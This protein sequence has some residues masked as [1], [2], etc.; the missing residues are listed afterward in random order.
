MWIYVNMAGSD[1]SKEDSNSQP[2]CE[3]EQACP[4]VH[5]NSYQG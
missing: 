3:C 5:R 4:E 1:T 2:K